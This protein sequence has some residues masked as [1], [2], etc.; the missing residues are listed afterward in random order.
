VAAASQA[1]AADGESGRRRPGLLDS[2][3]PSERQ[4]QDLIAGVGAGLRARRQKTG[5]SLRQFAKELGVSPAFVSQI[6]TGKSRPSVSTLYRMSSALGMT[7]DELFAEGDGS[8]ADDRGASLI[9]AAS[10]DGSPTT[11]R[12]PVMSASGRKRIVLDSGV[13]WEQLALPRETGV[14]FM[15]VRYQVGGSSTPE[16]LLTRHGGVDYGY[17][18]SGELEVTLGFESFHMTAGESIAFDAGTPHRL[19]NVG[20]TEVVAIWFCHDQSHPSHG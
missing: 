9:A 17:V 20:G 2:A 1:S 16:G 7:V 13:I 18:I 6:E 15:L 3:Q 8:Q 14:D 12:S 19:R 5:I 11:G 4:P 10:D